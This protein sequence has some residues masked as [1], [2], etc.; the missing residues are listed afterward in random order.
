MHTCTHAHLRRAR[1]VEEV[2]DLERD[3]EDEVEKRVVADLHTHTH[4]HSHAEVRVVEEILR[5]RRR[6]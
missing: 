1:R 6:S 2:A 4:T 3:L 5:V